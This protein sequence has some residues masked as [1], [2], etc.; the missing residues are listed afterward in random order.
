VVVYLGEVIIYDQSQVVREFRPCVS[1]PL[2]LMLLAQ[3]EFHWLWEY[4]TKV[5]ALN[6][7]SEQ[8]TELLLV[9]ASF[10]H[11]SI[12]VR[13]IVPILADSLLVIVVIV[14]ASP[15]D[16]R[17]NLD[18]TIST[19]RT[20]YLG[21]AELT[22]SLHRV[23]REQPTNIVLFEVVTNYSVLEERKE[24][25]VLS[26][27]VFTNEEF[28]ELIEILKSKFQHIFRN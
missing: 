6:D 2:S 22:Q 27:L 16:V 1:F 28:L 15:I 17:T 9:D 11:I 26:F 7:V 13:A 3:P 4:L 24:Y 14:L 25:C 18:T 5:R 8:S 21:I 20:H 10:R 12:S 23:N 19:T